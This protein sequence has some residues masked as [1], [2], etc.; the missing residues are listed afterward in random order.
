MDIILRIKSIF[1]KDGQEEAVKGVDQLS[2]STDKAATKT[3]QAK[4]AS[5]GASQGFA[6][7]GQAA[8]AASSGGI[9]SLAQ[10]ISKLQ[11]IITGFGAIGIIGA[12]TTA[13]N[14]LKKLSDFISD[15][16]NASIR[17]AGEEAMKTAERLNSE[18][19]KLAQ[20]MVDEVATS[21]DRVALSID[22]ATAAQNS[23]LAALQDLNT[24][25]QE[26]TALELNRRELAAL[27]ALQDDDAAGEAAVKARFAKARIVN[28]LGK[29]GAD[30][31]R[32]EQQARDELNAAAARRA[33]AEQALSKARENRA[34]L[35]QQ[36]EYATEKAAPH[37]DTDRPGYRGE[38]AAKAN[39]KSEKDL[40]AF[41]SKVAS[42]DAT[43]AKLTDI[44]SSQIAAERAAGIRL[45]AANVRAGSVMEAATGLSQ[46]QSTDIDRT[47]EKTQQKYREA[48]LK[49][50]E[51]IKAKEEEKTL[52]RAQAQRNVLSAED[53]R[54]AARNFGGSYSE[55][56][57]LKAALNQARTDRA[58]AMKAVTDYARKAAAD[59]AYAKDAVRNLPNN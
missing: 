2:A 3:N 32:G 13:Y 58:E 21:Y 19:M 1:N 52:T 57:E 4:V 36:L 27:A 33:A 26:A 9:G 29:R 47:K 17:A 12:I 7:A 31:I 24:A 6:A 39:A 37:P 53:N 43:I 41:T 54:R 59:A 25:Q 56:A 44:L 28:D 8:S 48:Q 50:L 42:L 45:Q 30:S 38:W 49:K 5:V 11:L 40:E 10:G 16:M 35:A 34:V 23:Y 55:I 46:Q 51:E 18:K 22:N 15:K 20:Q 14:L